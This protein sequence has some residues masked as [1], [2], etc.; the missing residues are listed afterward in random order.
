MADKKGA[1]SEKVLYCSFCGKSQ[2]EVKKLIA[3]PSVFICDECIELCNDIIRD[4]VPADAGGGKASRSD[5]P[6]PGEIKSLLDQYV[7]GQDQAKR[8][9]SVA[10]Y[11]HYKRLKHTAGKDEVELT[12]SNILLIGPTGSGKTLLA[13]TL[14]RMLNVPFVIAD[15]TTLTEA[16]YVGEDVEN[17]IQKL[18]QNCNYDVERA[19]RGIVYIDEIDKISR[20]ADNPSITRDVSGEG[21]QQA[22][23]KLV[24]GTMAS[25]PPQGGRKHPNQDFLQIDTTNILFI[26]GGAF[27]GLE[28]VIQNRTEKSGIGFGATVHSKSEKR[29][30]EMFREVEPEDLI[31]FGLIPELVGRLPVVATLG[32]L[33]EAALVQ[34][35]TEPKNALVKQYQ[36]L[37]SMDGVELEIR[38]SALAAIARKAL[39]RKTGARGLRSIMEHALIDTMFDLPNLDGVAKVVV[40]EHNI[41]EGAKPLLVY[42]EQA[43]ASA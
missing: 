19:Q 9:L 29:V 22:L 33:T 6:T 26:C 27:D 43:K 40:D 10:V 8:I 12:K 28:K 4:E 11:N 36:K 1:S 15:A 42:R 18:L 3:G 38:P 24:E 20:K 41:D 37:F 5:L 30:S 31:K 34:I 14:A 39:E 35:L 17:I 16:G 25:V 23:L 32:E 13:Q 21:V 7:I 2:H